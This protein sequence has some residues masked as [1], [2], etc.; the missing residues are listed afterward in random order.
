MCEFYYSLFVWRSFEVFE[1]EFIFNRVDVI[2][3]W[4][5]FLGFGDWGECWLWDC[6]GVDIGSLLKVYVLKFKEF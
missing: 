3:G 1:C 6:E 5:F 4:G 2:S